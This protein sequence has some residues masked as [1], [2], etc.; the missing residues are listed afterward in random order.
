MQLTV[1]G[2][3]AAPIR[4]AHLWG[5]YVYGFRPW[6]HCIKCFAAKTAKGI[7]PAMTDGEFQLEDKL[8]YLCGVGKKLSERRHPELARRFTNVHLAVR[9]KAGSVAAITSVYGVTFT[10]RDAEPIPIEPLASGDFPHLAEA[11]S[12]CKNFQFGYQM[13]EVGQVGTAASREIVTR[14]RGRWADVA[15]YLPRADDRG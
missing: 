6:T 12:R 2:L 3:N 15:E 1:T 7:S 4:F 10:I 9:P 13:F 11:H 5:R 8:F 14:L